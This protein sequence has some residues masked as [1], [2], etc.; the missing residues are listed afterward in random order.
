[1]DAESILMVARWKELGE[2]V[3]DVVRVLRS[4]IR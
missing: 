4:P 1:M 2:G 3:G